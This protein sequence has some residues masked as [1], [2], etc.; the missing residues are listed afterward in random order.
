MIIAAA[1]GC[2]QVHPDYADLGIAVRLI[3]QPPLP[4]GSINAFPCRSS[5]GM[6][7]RLAKTAAAIGISRKNLWERLRRLKLAAPDQALRREMEQ[8]DAA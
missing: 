6:T 3:A 7:G 4:M 8:G 1:I 5:C 2:R